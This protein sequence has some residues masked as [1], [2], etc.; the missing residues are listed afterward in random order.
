MRGSHRVLIA[1][2]HQDR[3]LFIFGF[4]KNDRDNLDHDEQYLYKKLSGYYLNVSISI[5]ER[6]CAQG[7][8]IEVSYDDSR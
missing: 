1:C 6:L 3:A 2:R 4:S 7:E 8:L 5:L